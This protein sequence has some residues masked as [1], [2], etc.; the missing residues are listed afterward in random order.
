MVDK[1][2][3]GHAYRS[4]NHIICKLHQIGIPWYRNKYNEIMVKYALYPHQLVGYYYFEDNELKHYVVNHH[5]VDMWKENQ[6][7]KIGDYVYIDQGNVDFPADN[8][9]KVIYSK[10]DFG[11]YTSIYNKIW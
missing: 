7:F 1:F 3:E 9:Y 5:Y 11:R 4:T 8:P 2:E 6:Q 10:Y